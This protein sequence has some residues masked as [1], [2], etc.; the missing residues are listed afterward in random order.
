MHGL[1][2]VNAK[3]E[4]VGFVSTMDVLAWLAGLR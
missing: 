4:L 2:V 1:P 3:A